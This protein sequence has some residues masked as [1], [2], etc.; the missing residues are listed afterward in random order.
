M[1]DDVDDDEEEEEGW[2]LK[3]L[4]ACVMFFES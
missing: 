4:L 1:V 2:E 3:Q